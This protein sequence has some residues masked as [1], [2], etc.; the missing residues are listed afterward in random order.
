MSKEIDDLLRQQ[1]DVVVTLYTEEQVRDI[2]L[3]FA[4]ECTF[5]RQG[6]AILWVKD[7]FKSLKQDKQ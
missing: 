3:K 6:I 1:D 4:E 7:Y 5:L 2:V